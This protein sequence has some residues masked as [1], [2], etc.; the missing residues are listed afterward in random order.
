MNLALLLN[1]LQIE[2]GDKIIITSDIL[3]ILLNFKKKKIDFDPNILI[4]LIKKKIGKKG[5][6]LI[7]TFNWD[8]CKGKTFKFH[9]TA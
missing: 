4:D 1:K 6:L 2:K 8:F 9:K 3:K 7:P 5:T